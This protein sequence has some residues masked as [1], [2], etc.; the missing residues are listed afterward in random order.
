MGASPEA[1]TTVRSL[2]E[3]HRQPEGS[4]APPEEVEPT[5]A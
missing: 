5:A 4:P 3:L 1:R 2:Q